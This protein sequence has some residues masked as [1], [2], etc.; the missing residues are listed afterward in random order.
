MTRI[1]HRFL[2]STGLAILLTSAAIPSAEA[3]TVGFYT[4]A[5]VGYAYAN[6]RQF[7]H[8]N[9]L[10]EIVTLEGSGYSGSVAAG[11]S[12]GI[13]GV[14][15]RYAHSS[16]EEFG[17][18]AFSLEGEIRAPTGAVQP[19]VRAQVGVGWLGKL[20][21]GDV[22]GALQG[23]LDVYGWSLGLGAGIDFGLGD[24]VTLGVGAEASLLNLTRQEITLDCS[25]CDDIEIGQDGDSL[26]LQVRAGIRLGIRL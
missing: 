4:N 14:G 2:A 10:P 18:N 9:F 13:G 15:V 24:A 11:L 12:I 1:F 21:A 26:G 7:R 20:D 8:T 17:V 16:F 6:L 3:S 22:P 23:E 5:D 19:F 25:G